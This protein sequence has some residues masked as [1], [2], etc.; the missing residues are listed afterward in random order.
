MKLTSVLT[1]MVAVATDAKIHASSA[2]WKMSYACERLCQPD[3]NASA[4]KY[5]DHRGRGG[6]CYHIHSG[7]NVVPGYRHTAD[8]CDK[9]CMP[10][11]PGFNSLCQPVPGFE[12]LAVEGP[13][14][15]IDL[16]Y[17]AK[18]EQCP[19]KIGRYLQPYCVDDSQT[20]STVTKGW[21]LIIPS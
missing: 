20:F 1:L 15:A 4:G 7:W 9:L 3:P 13:R 10:D 14:N 19:Y 6:C 12:K 8:F 16:F 21:G 17:E 11:G 5:C 18:P 2:E